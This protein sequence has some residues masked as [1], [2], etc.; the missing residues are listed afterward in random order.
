MASLVGQFGRGIIIMYT[1][2]FVCVALPA[3][4]APDEV[5]DA[6]NLSV[7]QSA[8]AAVLPVFESRSNF[9]EYHRVINNK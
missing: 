3:A 8:V 9:Y 4:D 6:R 5:V 7:K 1:L 2:W